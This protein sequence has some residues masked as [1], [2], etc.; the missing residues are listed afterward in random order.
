MGFK[1]DKL[2]VQ[3]G[4]GVK[5]KDWDP[6]ETI[7]WKGKRSAA[8]AR[9][10]EL[11]DQL[12]ALQEL[13]HAQGKHRVLVVLQAMDA[14]GKD[15]TVR[16]VFDGV[17]PAGVKVAPFRAP[18]ADE[19]ARDFL[20]RV[21]PHVPADGQLTIFNRS[22]YEDVLA[23]RVFELAPEEVWRKRYG[24]IRNFEQMLADEGTTIIKIYLHVSPEEQA[25][26]LQERLDDRSK[27]WKFNPSDINARLRWADYMEAFEEAIAE[28]ST[29]DAP[30][31]IIPA[32][33]RWYRNLAISEIMVQTLEG[34]NMAYPEPEGD[35]SGE[36]IPHVEW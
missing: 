32:N 15:S 7:E 36:T 28:T 24:H 25:G 20:W 14:A 16:H 11:N 35:L 34:L 13:L 9:T 23:V 2:R 3:P 6:D 5:L 1:I 22:H 27:W 26:H 4:S 33:R 10:A 21:H 31:Y 18:T 30:W 8:E 12:E 17:N 19:L 29:D